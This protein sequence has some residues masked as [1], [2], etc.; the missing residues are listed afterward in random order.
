MVFYPTDTIQ[1]GMRMIQPENLQQLQLKWQELLDS[2]ED[3]KLKKNYLC[4]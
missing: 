2:N 4:G 1:R 3:E